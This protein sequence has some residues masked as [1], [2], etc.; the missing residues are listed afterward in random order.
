M[1]DINKNIK[2]YRNNYKKR[3]SKIA[4]NTIS[5]NNNRNKAIS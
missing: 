3:F 4:G 5:S 1:L 2:R